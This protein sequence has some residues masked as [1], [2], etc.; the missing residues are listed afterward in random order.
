MVTLNST[1]LKYRVTITRS[2]VWDHISN[3]ISEAS[4]SQGQK[5]CNRSVSKGKLPVRRLSQE[6]QQ[7]CLSLRT[8][9]FHPGRF[10]ESTL[11]WQ[12]CK[13]EGVYGLAGCSHTI[14]FPLLQSK[15]R[16]VPI[17]KGSS[18]RLKV[19]HI[20][21]LAEF[22]LF[23]CFALFYWWDSVALGKVRL[24]MKLTGLKFWSS[25]FKHLNPEVTGVS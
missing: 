14:F 18:W 12:L 19:L 13:E 25:F 9:A 24:S 3:G 2:L 4:L 17:N 10:W 7:I 1:M 5:N 20:Y 23:V 22:I 8:S 15:S 11:A 21:M 16:E 6:H